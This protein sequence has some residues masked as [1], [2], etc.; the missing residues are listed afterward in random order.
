MSI[1]RILLWLGLGVVS[2]WGFVVST[3]YSRLGERKSL[4]LGLVV[5]A[6][7][8]LGFVLYSGESLR[9]IVI[10]SIGVVACLLMARAGVR[11]SSLW[12][13]AG[14][15]LHPLWDL[16]H[17][18]GPGAKFTPSWYPLACLSFDLYVARYIWRKRWLE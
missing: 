13:A 16:F 3:R 12:L 7:I 5:A 4:A 18:F 1:G 10:E 17:Y 9:W 6:L 2:A 8:Y 11:G 14:W 15:A